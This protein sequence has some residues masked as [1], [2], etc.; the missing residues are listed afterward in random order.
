M[1]KNNYFALLS[2]VPII[3]CIFMLYRL[4]FSSTRQKLALALRFL[5][6]ALLFLALAE[7]Q[8]DLKAQDTATIFLLDDSSSILNQ[9]QNEDFVLSASEHIGKHDLFG[10]AGFGADTSIYNSIN[11]DFTGFHSDIKLKSDATNYQQALEKTNFMFLPEQNKR[12]VLVTDGRENAGDLEK[13]LKQLALDKVTVDIH[14]PESDNFKEVEISALELPKRAKLGQTLQLKSKIKSNYK[15]E[16]EIYF[17]AGNELIE[18]RLLSLEVGENATI[19]PL[20]AE[21]AGF[22]ALRAEISSKD[23]TYKENNSL[24]TFVMVGDGLKILLVSGDGAGANY[25]AMLS[26]DVNVVSAETVPISMA[27]LLNY[28]AFI[29]ADVSLEKINPVFIEHLDKLV[30]EQGKGLLVSGGQNSYG[31]GGYY[32]SELE[33][34]LPVTADIS[35]QEE[36]QSLGLMLVIDKSSS[37]S[38]DQYGVSKLDLA[39]EAAARSLDVL[40]EKDKLGVIAFDDTFKAVIDYSDFSDKEALKNQIGTIRIGGGTS[41]MPALEKAID[42]LEKSNTTYRHIILLTD[43]QSSDEGYNQLMQRAN[44]AKITISTVA[45]GADADV[46]LLERI[47]KFANGRFYFTDIFSDIP[48]IFA[49]DVTVAGKKY[50]NNDDFYPSIASDSP[51]LAGIDALPELHGYVRTSLKPLAKAILNSD[52]DEP[53]LASFQYGLGK[54]VAFTS[55]MDGLWSKDLLAWQQNQ[56]LW[57]NI[58]AYLTG[59]K[60]EEE[61]ELELEKDAKGKKIKLRF[62]NP[63]SIKASEIKAN[64]TTP[65]GE[66]LAIDL[67]VESPGVY[68]ATADDLA[69]GVYLLN[70]QLDNEENLTSAFTVPYADEYHLLKQPKYTAESLASLTGGTVIDNASQ[71]FTSPLLNVTSYYQLKNL[72]LSLALIVFILELSIRMTNIRLP[73][74]KKSTK[75][76]KIKEKDKPESSSK[77]DKQETPAIKTGSKKEEKQQDKQSQYLDDLLK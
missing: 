37:M 62:A 26:A 39:K 45:V 7:P 20:K 44:N 6:I 67:K 42:N 65:E 28:D 24:S 63:Q 23:D 27:E 36:E 15:T 70:A 34:M 46:R 75:Q 25:P 54:T 32:A 55:D 50:I 60:S 9:K 74:M 64:I 56:L 68:V 14:I 31:L 4:S 47:A 61:F 22:N 69:E 5:V 11:Q 77:N 76:N 71:V 66:V 18:K 12:I 19:L 29:L 16:A 10:V 58:I 48:K 59:E 1:F 52:D 30:S 38:G 8:I 33:Q 2:L 49:K 72:L 51:V 40:S 35:D 53:I 57:Q 17:Y 41:I 21:K 73:F 3:I 43:G 13:A